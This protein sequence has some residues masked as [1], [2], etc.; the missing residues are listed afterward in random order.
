VTHPRPA[1]GEMHISD[2]PE[3]ASDDAQEL[4]ALANHSDSRTCICTFTCPAEGANVNEGQH[5]N[6]TTV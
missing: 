1:S 5:V 2:S 4:P 3:G 6:T